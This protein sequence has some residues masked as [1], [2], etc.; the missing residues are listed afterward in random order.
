MPSSLRS[1]SRGSESYALSPIR[2]S[3]W[4]SLRKA[5][6]RV[7]PTRVTSCGEALSVWRAR[8][9]EE[10][11]EN[12]MIFVPLPRLVFPTHAP[13][14]WLRQT[15]RLYSTLRGLSAH[16]LRGLWLELRVRCP[17]LLLRSTSGSADGRFGRVDSVREGPSRELQCAVSRGCRLGH[18]GALARAC[19]VHL[20]FEG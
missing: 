6:A 2:R 20:L 5:L 13:L 8:G 16:A 9:T 17:E 10:L 15:S 19:L 12:A 18:L 7:G 11:S 4:R 1:S 14:F 3:G